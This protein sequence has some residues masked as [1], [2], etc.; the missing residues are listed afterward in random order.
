MTGR[1]TL[2]VVTPNAPKTPMRSFRLD[3]ERWSALRAEAERR[4]LTITD[5]LREAIDEHL[6][7]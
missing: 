3:D 5:V 6:R 2:A 4:G 1:N 7:D